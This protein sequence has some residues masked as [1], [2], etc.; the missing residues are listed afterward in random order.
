MEK[1]YMCGNKGGQTNQQ[2]SQ[3]GKKQGRVIQNMILSRVK[4][5][6][7]VLVC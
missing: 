1:S 2:T 6:F 4:C 7:V 5:L 3:A